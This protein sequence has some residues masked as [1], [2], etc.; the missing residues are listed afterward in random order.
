MYRFIR[1]RTNRAVGRSACRQVPVS[2]LSTAALI[3]TELKLLLILVLPTVGVCTACSEPVLPPVRPAM[4]ENAADAKEQA[5]IIA[6]QKCL[7]EG[8]K[9][10]GIDDYGAQRFKCERGMYTLELGQSHLFDRQY[11]SF[12]TGEPVVFRYSETLLM[13]PQYVG[14]AKLQDANPAYYLEPRPQPR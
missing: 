5:R 11:S 9:D 14:H 7:Y 3:E 2:S 1:N 8:Y 13:K 6:G 10:L 4:I 12:E